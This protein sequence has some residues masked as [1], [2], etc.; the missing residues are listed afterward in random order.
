MAERC[1]WCGARDAEHTF[2]GPWRLRHFAGPVETVTWHVC[3][4][5]CEA[6]LREHVDATVR[7]GFDSLGGFLWWLLKAHLLWIGVPALAAWGLASLAGGS[8]D[9][10]ARVAIAVVCIAFGVAYVVWFYPVPIWANVRK[11]SSAILKVSLR[12]AERLCRLGVV[13]ALLV[14]AASGVLILLL[15]E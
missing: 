12:S 9:L 15:P 6:F 1:E 4:E 11:P 10:A 3:D 14:M 7:L 13:L 8:S 5:R 2:E